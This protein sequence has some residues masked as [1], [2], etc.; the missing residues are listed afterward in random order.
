MRADKFFSDRFGSR[1]KSAEA[2]KQ[3]LVLRDGKVLS[4]DSEVSEGDAFEFLSPEEQFVSNGGYKLARGLDVFGVDVSGKTYCDLG[5]STGGF[6]DCLLQNGAARVYA[7]DV[8]ESQLAPHLARDTRVVVMDRTNARY[9]GAEQFAEPIDGVTV[10]VSFISLTLILPAVARI[11][12]EG[13]H[14]FVL[15]KPQFE[16][17]GRGLN[18]HGILKDAAARRAIVEE[19]ARFACSLG[20][21]PLQLTNAPL[22]ARKNVEYILYLQKREDASIDCAAFARQADELTER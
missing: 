3:G 17:G 22:R 2:L 20:L 15:I 4:P 10:D 6:T 12:R 19:I 1:T 11:L 7:V 21:R 16:C 9:L 5:A 18:K 13:G 14:A 8:G